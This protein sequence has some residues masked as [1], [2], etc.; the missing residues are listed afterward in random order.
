MNFDRLI[1][2]LCA[3]GLTQTE[4]AKFCN[5]SQSAISDLQ[6]GES[7]QPRY[8]VGKALIDLHKKRCKTRTEPTTAGA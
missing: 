1:D 7:Q 2:D 3:V 4:I 8:S 6:R 5:C